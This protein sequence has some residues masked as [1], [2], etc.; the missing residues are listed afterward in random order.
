MYF[1]NEVRN[2]GEIGK[3]ESA[4]ISGAETKLATRLI[5]ELSND[6]FEP[7]KYEDEYAQHVLNL[8]KEKAE[9]EEISVSQTPPQRSNVI[10]IL[11]VFSYLPRLPK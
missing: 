11:E 9:G 5:D 7:E 6:D 8:V 3:G 4:K 1:A 2:F 10:D